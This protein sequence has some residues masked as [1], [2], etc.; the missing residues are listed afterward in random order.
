MK[1]IVA[2][3]LSLLMC[4]QSGVAF[5]MSKEEYGESKKEFKSTSYK[6]SPGLTYE[7][8]ISKNDKYGYER[9]YIYEY[10]PGEDTEIKVSSGRYLYG[11]KSLGS[12]VS[13]LEAEGVRVVGGVNGDFYSTATGVP[14]G[15]MISD[16]EII[17]SDNERMAMGFDKD[18]NAFISNP[19]IVT[20]LSNDKITLNIEH[21]NKYPLEWC[22]Y[23]LTDRFAETTK[24][25]KLSSEIVLMPYTEITYIDDDSYIADEDS[26]NFLYIKPEE[27]IEPQLPEED[28]D[29]DSNQ[30]ENALGND[31]ITVDSDDENTADMPDKDVSEQDLTTSVGEEINKTSES[32]DVDIPEQEVG[33]G[34]KILESD[35]ESDGIADEYFA[36][37]YMFSEEKLTVGCEIKVVVKEIRKD[38]KDSAIPEG[39]FVICAENEYQYNRIKDLSVGDEFVLTVTA[40]EPWQNA[41]SAIGDSGGLIVKDGEYF[42][43]VEID[44]Y[45][46]SNPRT[47]AGITEDGRVIFYCVDGRSTNSRGLN[48]EQLAYEMIQ[49]G[50]VTAINLDGGGSTTAYAALPGFSSSSLMNKPSDIWERRTANSL[51]FVNNSESTGEEISYHIYPRNAFVAVGGNRYDIGK[52]Y[53]SDSNF[54]PVSLPDDTE[55]EYFLSAG[56]NHYIED[57]RTF[58]SGELEE[59]VE[60]FVRIKQDGEI[61]EHLA[62]YIFVIDDV[63]SFKLSESEVTITP[64]ETV[65]V[66]PL[67]AHHTVDISWNPDSV[68][69][70]ISGNVNDENIEDTD[71]DDLYF[72]D[73]RDNGFVESSKGRIDLDGNFTPKTEGES[74]Y[75]AARVGS[76]ISKLKVNITD[77][78]FSDSFDHWAARNIFDIHSYGLM[79]GEPDGDSGEM[80]FRP[81]RHLTKAEF[82]TVLARMLYPDIDAE[83]EEIS[84]EAI[85]SESTDMIIEQ[86]TEASETAETTET[87]E[88]ASDISETPDDSAQ[89]SD[90]TPADDSELYEDDT[91]ISEKINSVEYYSD[92]DMIPSWAVKYF[93]ALIERGLSD[94][95]A[96]TAGDGTKLIKPTESITRLEVMILIGSLCE[97]AKADFI[98]VFVD[99]EELAEHPMAEFIN[100]AI[101][102]GIITGYED[103]TLRPGGSLTRAEAATVILRYYDSLSAE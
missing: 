89:M 61:S 15:A 70:Y 35:E 39:C 37:E 73:L 103:G 102:Q 6:I 14:I 86:T 5:A 8:K 99:S 46:T 36:K 2:I 54:Y 80:A 82:F 59:T 79:N 84:Q 76:N 10:T 101:S 49:L 85:A 93:D 19:G 87:V 77:Y 75:L 55:Y 38:S 23:L 28:A 97:Q 21:I 69:W 12:I 96:E 30:A 78:P 95:I 43:D 81:S 66:V 31:D 64:F 51:V 100:N 20:T 72:M 71:F 34:E 90:E 32:D 53:A 1:R 17:S 67:Y 48:I 60:I 92:G 42:T 68:L 58:V 63:E 56:S 88:T 41:V 22:L 44:H 24:S 4:A 11:T 7:E 83:S 29:S 25:T 16:G 13:E 26:R 62:G 45:S 98:D 65:C 3:A 91:E 9:E 52:L 27:V 18:G 40:N 74:F 94:L 47:A 50:C 57:G 33:A